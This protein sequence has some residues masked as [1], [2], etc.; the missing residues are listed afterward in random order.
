MTTRTGRTTTKF[1][2]YKRQI[3]PNFCGPACAQ[4][5]LES[6]ERSGITQEEIAEKG[7]TR[8]PSDHW[9][10]P[11][12]GW[13]TR[14]DEMVGMIHYFVDDRTFN[15]RTAKTS[16]S[17]R[18]L[19]KF[20]V[21]DVSYPPPITPIYWKNGHWVILF[22][23]Q[24]NNRRG[25]FNGYDPEYYS[26]ENA[27]PQDPVVV[28]NIPDTDDSFS[29]PLNFI[30]IVK[31]PAASG[32]DSGR[33]IEPSVPPEDFMTNENDDNTSEGSGQQTISPIQSFLATD[34]PK[35]AVEE[36]RAFGVLTDETPQP[37]LSP[38]APLLVKTPETPGQGYYL[39]GLE[40]SVGKNRILARLG[41]ETGQYLDSLTIPPTEYLFG[42]RSVGTYIYK[43]VYEELVGKM[44][45]EAWFR[46]FE[47]EISRDNSDGS[48][49]SN[50]IWKPCNEST[51]PFYPFY[52][53]KS[54]R[55]T[56]YV[57]IDGAVFNKLTTLKPGG[58][59]V[60]VK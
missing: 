2:Y 21:E 56:F 13:P 34:I 11:Y 46:A 27:N 45:R 26:R 28:I 59:G 42:R 51:S 7:D 18:K 50:L 23:H 41:T 58:K 3:S 6:M 4:M 14:P 10:K 33:A 22:Q 24:V 48:S 39:I 35:Q 25:S 19:L 5:I 38:G 16:E 31:R 40:T 37:G 44:N 60:I 43:L 1:P 52:Q 20:F 9:L 12:A 15:S 55:N 47:E 36:L 49:A 53:V 17:F 57:R 29:T 8:I 54:G 32:G 30:C